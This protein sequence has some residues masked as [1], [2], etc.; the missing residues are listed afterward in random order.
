[1]HSRCPL[2]RSAVPAPATVLLLG[3]YRPTIALARGLAGVGHRVIVGSCAEPSAEFGRGSAE[4]S[5]FTSEVW[6][7]PSIERQ[8][9]ALLAALRGFLFRRR[10]VA[11]VFPV[12]EHFVRL[13]SANRD[14]LPAD[15]IYVL[16]PE[17]L[18]ARLLDKVSAYR[19]AES[20]GLPVAPWAQVDRHED[21]APCCARLGYPVVVRPLGPG[22]L[23]GRK[24]VIVGTPVELAHM[25]PAWPVGQPALLLQRM[26]DGRRYNLYFAAQRGR[27]VRIAAAGVDRTDSP[28]GTGLAVT[29]RTVPVDDT[30]RA[31]TAT[32]ADR[33][34]YHGVGCAQYIVAPGCTTFLELNPRVGGNHAIPEAAGLGLGA[35]AVALAVPG[36]SDVPLVIG[37]PGIVFAWSHGD[38]A[39]LRTAIRRGTVSP[40]EMLVWAWKIARTSVTADLHLTWRWDDPLPT[41]VPYAR[42]IPALRRLLDGRPRAAAPVE[43]APGVT[44]P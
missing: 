32:L 17:E 31:Y 36:S 29:G 28:D 44:A 43:A 33:L 24:A 35:L 13:V 20:A 30:L 19:L 41:L 38:A 27:L 22:R 14:S 40:R 3:N 23:D 42:R 8:P 1:M 18:V 11:V 37:R 7:H 5:R 39:G 15:R 21:L 26:V 4:F 2:M 25:L 34:A 9:D 6:W 12:A 10:D 16:P